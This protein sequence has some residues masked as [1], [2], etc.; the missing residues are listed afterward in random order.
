M[1]GLARHAKDVGLP[2][3]AY[4][5]LLYIGRQG[6]TQLTVMSLPVNQPYKWC[7]VVGASIINP[8]P[9]P[10]IPSLPLHHSH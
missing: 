9:G 4:A 7:T 3:L 1:D 6:H 5:A 8:V 2:H 10:S